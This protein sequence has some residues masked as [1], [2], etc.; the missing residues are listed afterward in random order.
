MIEIN[1]NSKLLHDAVDSIPD[2]GFINNP[3]QLRNA[4]HNKIEAV[5]KM[6]GKDNLKGAVN[7][8][9]FDIK[10]KFVKWLIDD[11]QKEN[12]EQLSKVE[13]IEL[14]QAIIKRLSNQ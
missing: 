3:D 10:D 5:E 8:L 13:V 7:K 6:I 14:I 9:E 4:L 11:Y 12:P 1:P 2:Y